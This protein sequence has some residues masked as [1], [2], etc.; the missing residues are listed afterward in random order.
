MKALSVRPPWAWAIAHAGKRV[1][2]RSWSTR[3]RGPLLIHASARY[4][5]DELATLERILSR[6]VD[7]ERFAFGAI[8]ARAELYDVRPIERVSGRWA[9]GPWCWMLRDVRPLARPIPYSGQ[10][11]LWTPA[12]HAIRSAA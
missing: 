8:V 9:S 11:G 2:N 5:P 10:L 3:Y 4:G 12:A 1:E 7:P 6:R